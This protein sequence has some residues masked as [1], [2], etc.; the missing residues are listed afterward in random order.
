[1]SE[2][3]V[4]HQF[5]TVNGVKLHVAVAGPEQG[6]LVIL[7]HGFPEFWYGW[8][9]QIDVLADAGYRVVVPDQ[10]GYNTSDKPHGVRAYS[11][12]TLAGDVVGLI[13]TMG[14]ENATVI[15]HDW[16]AAVAWWTAI[17]HP[18][19]VNR[20]VI[21]NVP[22][23]IVM[24]KHLRGLKQMRKSWY[25][26]YFQLPWLPERGFL[27]GNC[28][29]A[30]RGIQKTA[31]QGTFSDADMEHYG[32]AWQQPGAMTGM[33]N[34]Y[35][36]AF[37][38]KPSRVDSVRVQAPTLII[39]GVQDQFLGEE[40]AQPS[41]EYCNDGRLERIEDATHWVQH[42]EPERVNHLLLDFLGQ[43]VAGP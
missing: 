40:M 23:P 32:E 3:R 33:I 10:R 4:E 18:Q 5:L 17:A 41:V 13:D 7:L 42:D 11:I 30:L 14:R 25:M 6:P 26:F 21:L 16:G 12:D 1:M 37:R 20:L 24:Q 36:A 27:K 19:R 43:G 28:R 34:W 35:R 31:R 8:R 15:G 2:P 39:W 38:V 29:R 22:H 9:H